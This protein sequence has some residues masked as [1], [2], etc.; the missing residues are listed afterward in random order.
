MIGELLL[1]LLVTDLRGLSD[2][3]IREFLYLLVGCTK[4]PLHELQEEAVLQL[5]ADTVDRDRIAEF[6]Y[7]HPDLLPESMD[8]FEEAL[9]RFESLLEEALADDEVEDNGRVERFRV[10]LEMLADDSDW[11][12]R[13][14]AARGVGTLEEELFCYRD[15]YLAEPL[16]VEECSARSVVAHNNLLEAFDAWQDAFRRAHRGEL[17]EALESAVEA[18]G[19]F[20]A[21]ERWAAT[22]V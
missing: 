4:A 1:Y 12:Q 14:E 20:V 13:S 3:D 18:T 19:L 17:D 22:E 8:G 21:V 10:C 9:E 6:P 15:G 11:Q 16:R 5:Q 2:D 7:E